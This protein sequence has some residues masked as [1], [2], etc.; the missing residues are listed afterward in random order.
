M[1]IICNS[2]L[3]LFNFVNN[4]CSF[5]SG[6]TH[7]VATRDFANVQLPQLQF[8][9]LDDVELMPQVE[10]SVRKQSMIEDFLCAYKLKAIIY[11]GSTA[12]GICLRLFNWQYEENHWWTLSQ[13]HDRQCETYRLQKTPTTVVGYMFAC[14]KRQENKSEVTGGKESFEAD[15]QSWLSSSA[16]IQMWTTNHKTWKCSK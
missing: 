3:W 9:R 1:N 8:R 12:T 14:R 6:G 13:R 7:A 10:K 11:M 4:E 5:W 16:E 2:Y 15:Y